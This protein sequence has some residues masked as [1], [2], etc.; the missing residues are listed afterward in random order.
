MTYFDPSELQC[1]KAEIV[2]LAP[3]FAPALAALRHDFGRPMRVNSCCRSADHNRAIGGHPRSLHLLRNPY[4]TYPPGHDCA[5]SPVETCAIDIAVPDGPY[6]GA[7]IAAAWN[8]G[9]SVGVARTFVHLD[10]R[11]LVLGLPQTSFL[12]N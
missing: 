11:S 5:G 8:A 6:R 2:V 1:P 7:L 9:F 3:G 4:W 12:Y 10:A